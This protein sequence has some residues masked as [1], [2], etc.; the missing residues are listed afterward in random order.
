MR[1]TFAIR[2]GHDNGFTALRTLMALAVMVGHA[3][4]IAARDL[5][6]EPVIYGGY[7]IS[8]MAV[9]AFFVVS[10]FLV[11]A[12]MMHR[13]G[14]LDFAVARG[15]RIY[16]ALV[17]HVAGV[18]LVVGLAN[19]T[20]PAGRYL[21]DPEV[22]LQFPRVLSFV[23]TDMFLPGVFE[24]NH[25]RYASAPLWTL[26]FEMLAYVGTALA[27]AVGA[28]RTRALIGAQFGLACL[29]WVGVQMWGGLSELPSSVQNVFRF[30]L[31]Y[32]LGAFLWAWREDLPLRVWAIPLLALAAV[33]SAGSVLG[34]ITMNIAVGYAVF[35]LAYAR[36][37][38]LD[39]FAGGSD[40]SYG[41]YIWHWPILQW[42]EAKAPGLGVGQMMGIALP[43]TLAVALLSWRWVE[44]PMLARKGEIARWL[45]ERG[46]RAEARRVH[47]G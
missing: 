12:S 16:P 33:V 13:R 19:T 18:A 30:A 41:V 29:A 44:K 14:L 20:L 31:P 46:R 40:I 47:Q 6:A 32:G 39:R 34:E 7:S 9:N 27:F 4:I 28:M 45:R 15:L 38:G 23:N 35:W 3:M 42:I 25:E 22:W 1:G 10:G 2:D 26:R 24:S 36:L 37:R 8:Y 11:T 21:A 5:S 17:V 43:A